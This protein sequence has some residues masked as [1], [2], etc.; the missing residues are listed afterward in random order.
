VSATE[1]KRNKQLTASKFT[2]TWHVRFPR[3]S[4]DFLNAITLEVMKTNKINNTLK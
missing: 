3:D 4:T 2:T 1:K